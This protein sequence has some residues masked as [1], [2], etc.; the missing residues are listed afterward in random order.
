MITKIKSGIYQGTITIPSSKSD[1]QRAILLAALGIEFST[2]YNI[3]N[4]DDE[5]AMLH[6]VETLG[7]TVNLINDTVV[8]IGGG[9]NFTKP[10]EVN[11]NE[12]GLSLRLL[13]AVCALSPNNIILKGKGSLAKRSIHLLEEV[14]PQ[15]DVKVITNNNQIPIEI[16]GPIKGNKVNINGS[17]SSQYISGLLIALPFATQDSELNISNLKSTP[18]IEMTLMTLRKFGIQIENFEF[19]KFIIKANQE[20]KACKYQVEGDWSSASYWIVAA[21]LGYDIKIKNL[22]LESKQAD[23]AIINILSEAGCIYQFEDNVLTID[24]QNRKPL[25]ADLTNCPDLFPAL[26]VYAAL[27]PGLS[28]LKGIHRLENKESNRAKTI[29]EEFNKLGCKINLED[30]YMLIDGSESI[31]SNEVFSHND[32]RI[33]MSLAI[34]GLFSEKEITILNSEVVSKSYPNFWNDLNS[35]KSTN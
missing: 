29:H 30:D 15:F 6:S 20:I 31:Y 3:G 9:L 12:S 32:H 19:D 8:K 5:K 4:S 14:L 23:K 33:A 24:G 34:L 7:A 22:N 13:A 11:V 27:T 17:L 28:R 25:L 1:S 21:A 18:Y 10:K 16:C 2:L 35:L 26:A